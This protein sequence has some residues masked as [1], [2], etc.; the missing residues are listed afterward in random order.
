[1]RNKIKT[2]R[3]MTVFFTTREVPTLGLMLMEFND[4][5]KEGDGNRCWRYFLLLLKAMVEP[6][7]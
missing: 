6:T 7:I 4:A 5:I 1:M 3:H 2:Q